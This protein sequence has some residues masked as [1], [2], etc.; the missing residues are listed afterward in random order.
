MIHTN[1]RAVL[2]QLLLYSNVSTDPQGVGDFK[3]ECKGIE[4]YYVLYKYDKNIQQFIIL[5]ESYKLSFL[6]LIF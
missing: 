3:E 1:F 5:L 4:K 6:S 2:L